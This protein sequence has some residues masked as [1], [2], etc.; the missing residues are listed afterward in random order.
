MRHK[1]FIRPV[2]VDLDKEIVQI[3]MPKGE[4]ATVDI[5]D[6]GVVAGYNWHLLYGGYVTRRNKVGPNL[7]H[8]QLFRDIPDNYIVDHID[9]DVMNNRRSNLRLCTPQQNGWNR[10]VRSWWFT[11]VRRVRGWCEFKSAISQNGV[12]YDL[13]T[14]TCPLLAA[15]AYDSAARSLRGE[16]ASLNKDTMTRGKVGYIKGLVV[17]GRKPKKALR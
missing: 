3:K 4:V 5:G 13:G 15:H 7:L 8:R 11:G 17:S 14:Y 2:C 6:Y 10:S 12:K 1:G 16:Y 9:R